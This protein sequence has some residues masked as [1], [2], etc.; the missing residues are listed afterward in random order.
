MRRIILLL[1]LVSCS[2]LPFVHFDNANFV[3]ELARTDAEK[4]QGLMHRE[5]LHPKHGM[6]FLFDEESPRT[7][8]MKNTKIPLDM[9]FLDKDM[10]VVEVK[11]NVPPCT[12]DP[13]PSS[14]SSP[15]QYV[16]EINAGLA[17]KNNIV[18]GSKMSLS[19]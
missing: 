1:L 15:A 6:L 14:P 13:C 18:V 12:E 7:F 8:W 16:L 9:V 5:S 3:V 19:E 2:T 17:E 11:A 10:V 4:A